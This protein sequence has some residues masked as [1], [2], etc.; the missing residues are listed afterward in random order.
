MTY[1][2]DESRL[3][4][5]DFQEKS[6]TNR[7]MAIVWILVAVGSLIVGLV[8]GTVVFAWKRDWAWVLPAAALAAYLLAFRRGMLLWNPAVDRSWRR[9]LWLER[10]ILSEDDA[11]SGVAEDSRQTLALQ[12]R[13]DEPR[14]VR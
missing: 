12:P 2:G 14:V 6:V 13:R 5:G 9:Y 4:K 8:G 11:A 10:E 7:R 3:S 1:S